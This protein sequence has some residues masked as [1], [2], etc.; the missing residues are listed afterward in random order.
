[1]LKLAEIPKETRKEIRKKSKISITI[2]KFACRIDPGR[3]R[4]LIC[5]TQGNNVKPVLFY[6]G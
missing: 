2:P 6:T 5:Q 3:T 1:M 4:E